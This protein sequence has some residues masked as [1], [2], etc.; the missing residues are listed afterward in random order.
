MQYQAVIAAPFAHLGV[1]FDQSGIQRIDF[2]PMA[3]PLLANGHPHIH[4]LTQALDKYWQNP[5]Y[6]PLQ[7]VPVS[8]S[9]T[10]HQSHVWQ[11][12]LA[13]PVGCTRYY[14]EIAAQITSSPRA[15]GQAC[16]ANPLPILIPCHRVVGK[17]G[18]GGFM[19]SRDESVLAYKQWLL[20]HERG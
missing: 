18:T 2:L 7:D 6:Q 4:E 10:P 13:I 12:L 16:G 5:T 15:V 17:V 3:T 11:A 20:N 14:G 8:Y 9:A 19:H 1:V